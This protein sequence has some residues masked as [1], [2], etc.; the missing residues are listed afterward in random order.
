MAVEQRTSSPSLLPEILQ[1]QHIL[2]PRALFGHNG[3]FPRPHCWIEPKIAV[4][5]DHLTER[6]SH[7]DSGA[8]LD[9]SV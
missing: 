6:M 5:P 9:W 1:G 2:V 4:K 8:S 7:R 3:H